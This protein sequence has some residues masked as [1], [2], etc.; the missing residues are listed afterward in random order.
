VK[1]ARFNGARIGRRSPLNA[2]KAARIFRE[3]CA[4]VLCGPVRGYAQTSPHLDVGTTPIDSGLPPIVG[5]RCGLF[6]KAGLDVKDR[7]CITDFAPEEPCHAQLPD[8]S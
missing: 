2:R 5:V 7:M 6:R 3:R 4:T 1:L 8:K